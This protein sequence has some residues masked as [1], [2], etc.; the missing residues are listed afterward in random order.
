VQKDE[1]LRCHW[2]FLL[3]SVPL[4][5]LAFGLQKGGLA[6]LQHLM[7]HPVVS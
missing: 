3:F 5:G 4:G 7:V 1:T 6:C 2:F